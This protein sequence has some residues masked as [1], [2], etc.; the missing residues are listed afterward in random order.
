MKVT[1]FTI[2]LCD[3][4]DQSIAPPLVPAVL[5]MNFEFL[6][7]V[8][9]HGSLSLPCKNTAPP[10]LAAVLLIHV[11]LSTKPNAPD[12]IIAPPSPPLV[13]EPLTDF[14]DALPKALL[15][16][17]LEFLIVPLC[18]FQYIAPPERLA[19]LLINVTLSTIPL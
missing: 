1:L 14:A 4:S 15:N 5:L 18:P 16:K 17:N 3:P 13:K 11:T 8:F 10:R 6:N 12:Q 19:V 7:V 9:S 2:P